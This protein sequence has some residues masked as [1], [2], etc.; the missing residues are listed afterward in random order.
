MFKYVE[1]KSYLSRVRHLCGKIMQDFCHLLKE[2]YNIGANFYLVGSGARNLITQNAS[3]PIDLDYN[4]EIVRCENIHD[5]RTIKEC[6]RKALNQ[7]LNSH[8]LGDCEDSTSSL[9]T[10]K[11]HFET[12]NPTEFSIDICIT[13]LDDNGVYRLIHEKTRNALCDGYYWNKAPNSEKLREKAAYIKD[14]GEWPL[15]REQYLAI[16]NK[17]LLPAYL[18]SGKHPSF[19]CYIEA[20]NAVYSTLQNRCR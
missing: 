15:V 11:F 6:A 13:F 17:Y 4:L 14:C 3:Q 2:N 1:D 5:R 8:C 10:K 7:V 16:K 19:S 20:V 9:T 18:I 12:G